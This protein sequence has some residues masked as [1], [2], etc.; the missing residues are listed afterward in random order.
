M[1]PQDKRPAPPY[2]SFTT[3]NNF[4]DG[5]S[6]HMPTR[7]DKSLMKSMSG[8]SQAALVSALD[9]L[10]L[11]TYDDKPSAQLVK[12]A[13]VSAADRGPLWNLLITAKYQFLFRDEFDLK[14]ATQGEL[15]ERFR[16]EGITGETIRKCVAFFMAAAQASGIEVSPY[17]RSVKSR[18]PRSF[19]ARSSPVRR[20]A[21]REE[22][23]PEQ[24][25]RTAD[26]DNGSYLA[27]TV[28]FDGDVIAELRITG[29]AFA[30]SAN[31]R[32]ALFGWIDNMKEHK[33]TGS[34]D[35]DSSAQA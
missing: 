25:T 32:E 18:A 15:E 19:G 4:I 3:L 11:R 27:A 14:R 34:A 28:R 7:I 10:G 20:R 31:D 21:K 8:A 9:Y 2:L 17:F 6:V 22:K 29:N 24:P 23:P 16:A 5:L 1:E 33:K 13:A 35:S 30:L 26:S 12:L